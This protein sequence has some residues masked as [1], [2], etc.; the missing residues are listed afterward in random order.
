ML[1]AVAIATFNRAQILENALRSI[2]LR[3]QSQFEVLVVNDGGADVSEIVTRTFSLAHFMISDCGK[4]PAF[5]GG[6][7]VSLI[8][9]NTPPASQAHVLLGQRS[10]ELYRAVQ[11]VQSR[12]RAEANALA[13]RAP[14]Q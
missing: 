10:I 4:H 13:G 5:E 6:R 2:S 3:T 1:A 9:R 7:S 12:D 14:R 11:T 8:P